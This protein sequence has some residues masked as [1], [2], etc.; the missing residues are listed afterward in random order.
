[1]KRLLCL[2]LCL[3]MVLSM[4]ACGKATTAPSEKEPTSSQPADPAPEAQPAPETEP[5]NPDN[6]YI[7]EMAA[8]PAPSGAV[9]YIDISINPLVR[10][11]FDVNDVIIEV[12]YLNGDAKDAFEEKVEEHKVE[13]VDLEKGIRILTETAIEK[14]YLKEGAPVTVGVEIIEEEAAVKADLEKLAEATVLAVVESE[15]VT[16]VVTVAES[17]EEVVQQHKENNKKNDGNNGNHN[18]QITPDDAPNSSQQGNGQT[19]GVGEQ[20]NTGAPGNSGGNNNAGGDSGNN[21]NN[22]PSVDDDEDE[23]DDDDDGGNSWF[24]GIGD[25]DDD[26]PAEPPMIDAALITMR[27]ESGLIVSANNSSS[28]AADNVYGRPVGHKETFTILYDGQAITDYTV[29]VNDS[30]VLSAK[31]ENGKISAEWLTVGE[32]YI[33]V[34]YQGKSASFKIAVNEAVKISLIRDGRECL[35]GYNFRTIDSMEMAV[36]VNG[37]TVTDFTV[38]SN[39]AN[40]LTAVNE[41]GRVVVNPLAVGEGS[42][43][44]SHS[45]QKATY[46]VEVPDFE[47]Q[48]RHCTGGMT[49]SASGTKPG[50]EDNISIYY[51]DKGHE[52][53]LAII[54]SNEEYHEERSDFTFW[55]EDPDILELTYNDGKIHMVCLEEGDTAIWVRYLDKQFWFRIVVEPAQEPAPFELTV[56]YPDGEEES[57]HPGASFGLRRFENSAPA[58]AVRIYKDGQLV[59]DAAVTMKDPDQTVVTVEKQADGSFAF[60][61]VTLGVTEF[62]VTV[63]EDSLDY[64]W[65]GGVDWIRLY[66]NDAPFHL[67]GM[68]GNTENCEWTRVAPGASYHSYIAYDNGLGEFNPDSVSLVKNESGWDAEVGKSGS[69]YYLDVTV[70]ADATGVHTFVLRAS[71]GGNEHDFGVAFLVDGTVTPPRPQEKELAIE[72]REGRRMRDGGHWST[73]ETAQSIN[74][75]YGEEIITEFEVKGENDSVATFENKDG[76]LL[77]TPVGR[78]DV[79]FTIAYDGKTMRAA[80]GVRATD[81]G[82]TALRLVMNGQNFNGGDFLYKFSEANDQVLLDVIYDG[83]FVSDFTV[84]GE[85]DLIAT[86]GNENGKLKIVPKKIGGIGFTVTYNNESYRFSTVILRSNAV[87]IKENGVIYPDISG[88]VREIREVEVTHNGSVVT[89]FTVVGGDDSIA[90]FEIRDGKLVIVPKA[91][92]EVS[93][94]ITCGDDWIERNL[95]VQ[96]ESQPEPEPADPFQLIFKPDD[97]AAEERTIPSDGGFGIRYYKDN[98]AS[99]VRVEKDGQLVTDAVIAFDDPDQT[100]VEVNKQTDGTFTFRST[101]FGKAPFTVTVGE[102][103]LSYRWYSGTE[104]LR[105]YNAD[106]GFHLA[107]AEVD[108]GET[109]L[110]PAPAEM[111]CEL[112]Y[113]NGEGE[114]DPANAT[115]F[116]TQGD[117]DWTAQIVKENDTYYLVASVPTDGTGENTFLLRVTYGDK[118][119]TFGVTFNVYT[120]EDPLP[121][122]INTHGDLFSNDQGWAHVTELEE[123]EVV[124]NGQVV[125]DFQVHG[126][127]DSIATFAKVNGKIV[128]TPVANGM[129]HFTVSYNGKT[130]RI[131]IEVLLDG[132]APGAEGLSIARHDGTM[133]DGTEFATLEQT[134]DLTVYYGGEPC[135]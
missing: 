132:E 52:E 33:W 48:M 82:R 100:T 6:A 106:T 122:V 119:Q 97:E 73:I 49:V 56:Q 39:S 19:P 31:V 66:N 42:F 27:H 133:G 121:G 26:T 3:A 86:F 83:A 114:Y 72:H 29:T 67:V 78:G 17:A 80:V 44:V 98:P 131:F 57:V 74:V 62:T 108:G 20:T 11:Y 111:K 22:R 46:T 104:M 9:G 65:D 94:K 7:D 127:D 30:R 8:K 117:G 21:G 37:T 32:T 4:A 64:T 14:G 5:E 118:T 116:Q 68:A 71:Y 58:S 123:W 50:V 125:T 84:E 43:T 69:Q 92:G 120:E 36:R 24:P 59:P 12:R 75:Y 76:K 18:G 107:A 40:I 63:G 1:M 113:D 60:T 102:D 134:E 112:K 91:T 101:G 47:I 93:Y 28:E 99:I 109:I 55:A 79:G 70:P 23:D 89:D 135:T 130:S 103:T 53:D 16:A 110:L 88:P 54:V 13:G 61:P 124:Y 34:N 129:V 2:L 85:N 126:E 45:G 15:E 38:V 10:L 90:L 25:D 128:A 35:D 87:E 41:A 51:P 105:F 96:V 95:D 77:I 115:I 81:G